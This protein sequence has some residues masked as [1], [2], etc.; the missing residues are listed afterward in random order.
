MSCNIFFLGLKMIIIQPENDYFLPM[1]LNLQCLK[2]ITTYSFQTKYT[3]FSSEN[4]AAS[5]DQ[6]ISTGSLDQQKRNS[7]VYAMPTPTTSVYL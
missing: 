1:G 6:S 5:D 4:G 3:R 2:Y 7:H